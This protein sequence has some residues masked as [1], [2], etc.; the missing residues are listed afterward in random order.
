M[1]SPGLAMDLDEAEWRKLHDELSRELGGEV[2]G[3]QGI[4]MV[5]RALL[6]TSLTSA[7]GENTAVTHGSPDGHVGLFCLLCP[8]FLMGKSFSYT[9][10]QKRLSEVAGVV[11]RRRRLDSR[12]LGQAF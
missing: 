1:S 2:E 3:S 12:N 4:E 5:E 9:L 6:S 8:S 7:R 11:C 10:A